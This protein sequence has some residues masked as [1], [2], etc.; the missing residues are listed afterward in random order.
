MKDPEKIPGY[1]FA[2]MYVLELPGEG[3]IESLQ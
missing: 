3:R 2:E 1:A